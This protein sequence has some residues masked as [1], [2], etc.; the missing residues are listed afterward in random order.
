M[1]V[2]GFPLTRRTVTT[3]RSTPTA[4]GRA[5]ASGGTAAR[6]R[7]RSTGLSPLADR[8]DQCFGHDN[9]RIRD[10]RGQAIVAKQLLGWA[11]DVRTCG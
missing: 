1:N 3:S 10:D 7:L 2:R 8:T 9:G 4:A 6:A 11:E 5:P